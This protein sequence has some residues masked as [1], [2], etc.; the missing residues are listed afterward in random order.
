MNA[1]IKR[2]PGSVFVDVIN[3]PVEATVQVRADDY[4][5]DWMQAAR[6]IAT[7]AP[8]VEPEPTETEQAPCRA[9]LCLN[10]SGVFTAE[11]KHCQK[12]A[13]CILRKASWNAKDSE[14][15]RAVGEAVCVVAG[16]ALTWAYLVIF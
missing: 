1:K 12:R 5:S 8:V 15:V 16:V 11:S 10:R 2:R 6:E 3:P 13:G 9:K 4:F 7:E 14:W